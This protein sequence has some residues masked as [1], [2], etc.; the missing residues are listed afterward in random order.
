MTVVASLYVEH[1]REA[2][3]RRR[4]STSSVRGKLRALS[5]SKCYT[6]DRRN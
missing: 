3:Y 6:K 1:P 5:L 2:T 4:T